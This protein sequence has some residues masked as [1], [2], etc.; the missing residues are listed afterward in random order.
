MIFTSIDFAIFFPII[1]LIYWGLAV[2]SGVKIRN[3]FV[4]IASYVF[5][6]WWN[7]KACLLLFSISLVTWLCGYGMD[8]YRNKTPEVE[9]KSKYKNPVYLLNLLSIIFCIGVLSFFKYCDFFIDSF[10]DFF[11]LL[12]KRISINP[13]NIILPIGIS[14]YVFQSLTY[15][16]DI[17][18]RKISHT[19]DVIAYFAFMSFFP[20]ILAGPIGRA[21]KLI[22]QF[23]NKLF[24]S[25]DFIVSGVRQILWGI[26]MKVCVADRL[27]I[28]VDTIYNNLN[29][30]NGGSV[31]LAAI[32]YSIQIYCDFAGYSYVAIGCARMLGFSLDENFSRPYFANSIGDFWRR[33]HI[34]LSTWFRDYVYIP[35]GGNRVSLLRNCFN[36]FVT[37]LVSGLWHGAAWSF[38][39]W[40]AIHG[41][42]Q[43]I[44][45]LR[46]KFLHI[47]LQVK[48]GF[49]VLFT[50]IL[51][52]IAWIFFRIT[53]INTAFQALS[54]IFYDF[55]IPFVDSATFIYGGL[56][57]ILLVSI[58]VMFE[59]KKLKFLYSPKKKYFII[60]NI[61]AI[62]LILWIIATGVFD[63][64]QFIYFQF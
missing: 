39:F 47:N 20:Q 22:P 64:G 7:W 54:K 6:G 16:I 25:Y 40:G 31:A 13:I 50:F 45:K 41:V 23:Q 24:F 5:Y 46:K 29:M 21:Y 62:G 14:F 35:L 43:I 17:Y 61:G 28:Y 53:D 42:Y 44:E 36:L 18:R 38:V 51:T 1:F 11:S 37:F 30:H 52:T 60:R 9:N 48:N 4:I 58:E 3:L 55:G 59:Y 10:V 63:G 26:F 34:S 8:Y 2:N 56:S 32:I 12:G 27:S 49:N 33:W 15:T 57:F 19:D